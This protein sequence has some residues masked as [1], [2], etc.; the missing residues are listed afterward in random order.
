MSS[1][2]SALR[3]ARH[4]TMVVTRDI[5]FGKAA[6]SCVTP[7]LVLWVGC[8]GDDQSPVTIPKGNCSAN[9]E[10]CTL[11]VQC[12]SGFCDRGRCAEIGQKGNYGLECE[13]GIIRSIDSDPPRRSRSCDGYICDSHRCRSCQSDADCDRWKA[14]GPKCMSVAGWPGKRCAGTWPP[15]PPPRP[16]PSGEVIQVMS[17]PPSAFVVGPPDPDPDICI[18]VPCPP[19]SLQ[20]YPPT[21]GPPPAIPCEQAAA[22]SP[23][24]S[25]LPTPPR[26]CHY[27]KCQRPP[28]CSP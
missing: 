6:L 23:P 20:R 4:S 24:G 13:S 16:P 17:M 19:G 7:V 2:A 3:H 21:C 9:G 14:E 18:L 8:I 5:M 15:P 12:L 28:P 11:D 25:T 27:V 22:P 26:S 1:S 10:P